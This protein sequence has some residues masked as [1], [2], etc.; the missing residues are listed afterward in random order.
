MQRSNQLIHLRLQLP[1]EQ[2]M[3]CLLHVT[4]ALDIPKGDHS[5]HLKFQY[6]YYGLAIQGEVQLTLLA[7]DCSFFYSSENYPLNADRK[8][9]P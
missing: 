1:Y 4:V 9:Q 8:A 2:H 7:T 6:S 5:L 3:S